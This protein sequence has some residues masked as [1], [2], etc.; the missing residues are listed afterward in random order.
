MAGRFSVETVF[1][2]V[3]KM[4]AP[5]TRMQNKI[6]RFTRSVRK[7]LN[8]IERKTRDVRKGFMKLAK[9]AAIGAAL[10]TAALVAVVNVGAEFEQTL[11][12]AAAKFPGEIRK[13]TA[14]FKELEN[15]ARITGKTT[16]F[17]AVASAKA[18]NFLAMAGFNAE[19]SIAALPGVVD[20]ATVAQTDLQTATDIATDSLGAFG[21]AT[22]DATQLGKN[23]A[24]VN[25]AIAL[26]SVRANTNIETMFEAIKEGAPV[27]VKAGASV[28]TFLSLT[29][30]LA[31]AGIKGTRAGTTLKNMFLSLSAPTAAASKTLKGLGVSTVDSEG[32][33]KDINGILGTLNKSMAKL[34]TAQRAGVLKEIFGKIPIAGVNVLLTAGEKKL[35]A[36]RKEL[37]RAAGSSK[38]MAAVMR[39]TFSGSMKELQSTV[40][41]VG[42]NIF[43][44]V[45]GP[46]GGLIESTTE[47]VR[48]NEDLITSNIEV[49]I[50]SLI[51]TFKF[52]RFIAL[53]VMSAFKLLMVFG[54]KL[55]KSLFFV[56]KDIKNAWSGLKQFFVTLWD[57]IVIAFDNGVDKVLQLMTDFNPFDEIGKDLGKFIFDIT[58]DSNVKQPALVN[59]SQQIS[60]SIEEKNSRSTVTI[61]DE[62]G[63]AELTEGS[64][65]GSGLTLQ[66]SGGF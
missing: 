15:A 26:T 21:L 65:K 23:L 5:V 13:G 47:W 62:T 16:E 66:P 12:N 61:K 8:N 48:V 20:L 41:G 60:R 34:G 9:G 38:T 36:F 52:L 33:L 2:A 43:D 28:E 39:D 55:G 58:S 57:A 56:V 3:D 63:R 4:T 29:G 45:K 44:L 51:E 50:I 46:L 54:E 53:G 7:G 14:A 40:E 37:D 42:L 19:Q 27:A 59:P 31:N 35:N 6:G 22:K 10:L 30:E 49:F 18:L 32:N 11:V 25:D 64:L 17:T 1:K 24:R